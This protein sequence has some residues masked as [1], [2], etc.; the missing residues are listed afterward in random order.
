MAERSVRGNHQPV[1]VVDHVE[2]AKHK[3]P[4][5]FKVGTVFCN[6]KSASTSLGMNEHT[7][8]QLFCRARKANK[9]TQGGVMVSARG[10]VL[11]RV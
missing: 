11:S 9:D 3:P 6:V 8:R 7:L 10:H 2:R 1:R 4:T 5:V